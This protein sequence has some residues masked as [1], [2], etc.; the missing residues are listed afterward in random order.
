MHLFVFPADPK[1]NSKNSSTTFLLFW[2]WK[3]D[4]EAAVSDV[5][6]TWG[7]MLENLQPTSYV[8]LGE[9][10][11]LSGAPLTL[12]GQGTVRHHDREDMTAAIF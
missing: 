8:T 6:R 1:N 11:Y 9:S 2:L 5:Q 12:R 3:Q 10:L 7:L 4:P